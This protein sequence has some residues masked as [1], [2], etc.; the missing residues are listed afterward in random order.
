MNEHLIH[1][2]GGWVSPLFV[3]GY[4][5]TGRNGVYTLIMASGARIE[6]TGESAT[7]LN[8]KLLS[9]LPLRGEA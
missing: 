8:Q 7:S 3:Q 2:D 9:V 5:S 6:T 4:E 1:I